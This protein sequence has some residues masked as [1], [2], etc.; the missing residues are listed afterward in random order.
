MSGGSY[1]YIGFKIKDLANDI[2][3]QDTDP[4]RA[5]F[6][7]LMNL[8]GNAMHD[9][10]WVDSCDYGEGDDHKAI[11]AV[12]SFLEATPDIIKKAHAYDCLVDRLKEFLK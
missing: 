6:A 2:R 7:K 1:D 4:R 9:I 10:E 8:V 5:T 12:F 11:D 3:N